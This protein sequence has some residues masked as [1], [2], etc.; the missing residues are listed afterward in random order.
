[1]ECDETQLLRIE[2]V[3]VSPSEARMIATVG[4][5][6]AEQPHPRHTSHSNNANATVHADL[7][8]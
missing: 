7:K 3:T 6:S 4:A 5:Q 1:M 2:L 8:V